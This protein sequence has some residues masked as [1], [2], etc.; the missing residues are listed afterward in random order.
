MFVAAATFFE[1]DVGEGVPDG[2]EVGEPVGDAAGSVVF[3]PLTTPVFGSR[4]LHLLRM[5]VVHA[6][7]AL[8]SPTWAKL[9]SSK[10]CRQ[11]NYMN[12]V[13][14]NQTTDGIPAE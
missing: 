9:Q 13:V 2:L 11:M 10:A 5:S 14:S 7:W 4:V 3:A 8:A 6:A 12:Q 1:V